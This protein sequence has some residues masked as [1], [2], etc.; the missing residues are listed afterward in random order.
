MLFYT[1]FLEK[2]SGPKPVVHALAARPALFH[3]QQALCLKYF[4]QTGQ[5]YSCQ[6]SA[7][8]S[9]FAPHALAGRPLLGHTQQG[10]ICTRAR[11]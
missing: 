3:A 1:G 2:L 4:R 8:T 7:N 5:A 6:A 9:A 11:P 10:P